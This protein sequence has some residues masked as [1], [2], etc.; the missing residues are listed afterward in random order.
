[1]NPREGA[2]ENQTRKIRLGKGGFRDKMFRQTECERLKHEEENM[3]SRK[4]LVVDDDQDFIELLKFDLK[5]HHYDIS[6]ACSAREGLAKTLSDSPDLI[7]LDIKMP[8]MNGEEF[9]IEMNKYGRKVPIVVLTNYA[10]D[11]VIA[12]KL[13]SLGAVEVMDKRVKREDLMNVISGILSRH[14]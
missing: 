2:P 12:D 11:P 4:V 1:M 14:S 5:K 7:L 8:E 3:G 6:V 9:M 13:R 10:D